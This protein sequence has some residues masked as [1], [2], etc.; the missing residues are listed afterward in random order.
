MRIGRREG[1]RNGGNAVDALDSVG[2]SGVVVLLLAAVGVGP[3]LGGSCRNH[4]SVIQVG[5]AAT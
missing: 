1:Q 4:W 2:T 3:S 5:N